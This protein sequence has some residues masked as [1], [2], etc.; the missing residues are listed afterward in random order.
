M[1]LFIGL[2]VDVE[3]NKERCRH[4]LYKKKEEDGRVYLRVQSRVFLLRK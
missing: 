4:N 2:L 3:M 1:N